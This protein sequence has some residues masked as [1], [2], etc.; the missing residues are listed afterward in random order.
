MFHSYTQQH[1]PEHTARA[2]AP[3]N[4]VDHLAPIYA[5]TYADPTN[6][7]HPRTPAYA[8]VYART[9]VVQPYVHSMRCVGLNQGRHR[10]SA[11]PPADKPLH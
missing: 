2:H 5:P 10:P 6:H 1:D 4:A 7:T 9:R 3:C 8:H 11:R